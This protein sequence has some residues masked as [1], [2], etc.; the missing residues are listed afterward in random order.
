MPDPLQDPIAAVWTVTLGFVGACLIAGWSGRPVTSAVLKTLASASFIVVAVL[1]GHAESPHG[2]AIIAALAL[3][4]LG[5]LCLAIKARPAFF[6][7]LAA[8]LGGHVAY[9][10]AFA[11]RG[12]D[13]LVLAGA[14][15]LLAVPAAVTARRLFPYVGELLA[16]VAAYVVVVSAMLAL[17]LAATAAGAHPLVS[18]GAGL[19]YVSDLFVARERFVRSRF[20][21]RLIG[22]PLYYLG[23]LCLAT[24]GGL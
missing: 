8:F 7:G 20:V 5:D 19:F 3:C 13:P 24:Y 17:A 23:Q 9:G 14:A 15:A 1:A 22:L 11:L 12:V 16:P 18:V 10:V 4:A 2:R 6:A 21:H